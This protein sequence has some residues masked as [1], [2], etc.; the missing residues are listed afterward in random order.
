M[1]ILTPEEKEI[2]L[3]KARQKRAD[4]TPEQIQKDKERQRLYDEKHAE[5]IRARRNSNKASL[6]RK[7]RFGFC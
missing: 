1:K 2:K 5:E 7:P 6:S 3:A 4:R